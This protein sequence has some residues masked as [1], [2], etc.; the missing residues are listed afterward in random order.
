MEFF[1]QR[2]EIVPVQLPWEDVHTSE[3][4]GVA[5][6]G[7]TDALYGWMGRCDELLSDQQHF[8]CLG[9]LLFYQ[10]RQMSRI[11]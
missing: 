4:D 7:I 11:A 6:Y 8:R 9:R 10:F 2:I 5:W 3:L 1:L